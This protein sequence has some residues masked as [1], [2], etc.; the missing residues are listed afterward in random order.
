MCNIVEV[1]N[2]S[3][4]EALRVLDACLMDETMAIERFL[5]GNEVSVWSQVSKK[6]KPAPRSGS[7]GFAR[8]RRSRDRNH[9]HQHLDSPDPS[10][11]ATGYRRG[12]RHYPHKNKDYASAPDPAA[13][14][15]KRVPLSRGSPA[16]QP[17]S[18]VTALL[19]ESLGNNY[20]AGAEAETM[21]YQNMKNSANGDQSFQSLA[22]ASDAHNW[23]ESGRAGLISEATEQAWGEP[24][25]S[26][27]AESPWGTQESAADLTE[28]PKLEHDPTRVVP[29]LGND[30][31]QKPS[32]IPSPSIKRTFNYAAAAAAGTSHAKPSP[33]TADMSTSVPITAAVVKLPTD[34]DRIAAEIAAETYT[35]ETTDSKKR[36]S[37]AGRKN[38]GRGESER[39]LHETNGSRRVP[40]PNQMATEGFDSRENGM[41]TG[42]DEVH[43]ESPGSVPNAWATRATAT[44]PAK[45]S[46]EKQFGETSAAVGVASPALV[47]T[48][49]TAGDALNLQFGSFGLS[50]L[51]GVNW[52]ASEQKV[53]EPVPN[54]VAREPLPVAPTAAVTASSASTSMAS[55]AAPTAGISST[56]VPLS[57]DRHRANAVAVPVDSPIQTSASVA[58][59]SASGGTSGSGMFPILPVG[60]G[61]NFPPPNYGAPY[62]MPPLHGYAPALG[63][64]ENAGDLG[65]SRAPN[66]GP[67]GSLP[68]YDPATL[69]TMASGNAKYAG[70][71]GLGEMSGLPLV[72]GGMG[73]DSLQVTSDMDKSNNVG[74]AGLP[75]GMDALAAPYMVPGYPSMQYPMYTFPNAPYAPPPGM[76]PPG[77]N[78]FPYAPAGQV[79]AQGARGGFGF[80]DCAVGPGGASR[81]GSGAGESMYTPGGYLNT[82]VSHSVAHSGSQKAPHDAPYKQVRGNSHPGSNVGGMS[83]AGG[84]IHGMTYGDYSTGIPGIGNGSGISGGGPVSWNNRQPNGGRDAVSG[85]GVANQ[86]IAGGSQNSTLY[87]AAPGGTHG[88]Y[89][90]PQ[91]GGY[92][93]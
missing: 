19:P 80:E 57:S 16:E 71:P 92:Y 42:T 89:W 45:P 88:G 64:Y 26:A 90:T 49:Q 15:K 12:P 63:S 32:A 3:R 53:S 91:Q 78:P 69:S 35:A 43:M 93:P 68:L 41:P 46:S 72:P 25:H 67:P 58:I 27:S 2:V 36:R 61:G 54:T 20:G 52:S 9:H 47:G 70:I 4:D 60:P 74:S 65:S 83:M 48:E 5:S 33:I 11:S 62:L 22:P 59:P 66:L 77:P 7:R 23:A 34:S 1:C 75:A 17:E 28:A 82:S 21:H 51:D 55:K 10:N 39:S 6:K 40:S 29:S 73:K 8:E 86:S 31:P 14:A 85:P 84:I 81:S 79:S 56:A 76:A 13:A 30:A 37:R 87:G 24:S 44:A 38:R 50:R 18:D